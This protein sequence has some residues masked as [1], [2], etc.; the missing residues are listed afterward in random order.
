VGTKAVVRALVLGALACVCVSCGPRM[1]TQVSEKPY[2]SRMPDMPTGTVPTTG[3]LATLTQTQSTLKT[4]PLPQT[5]ETID[6]GRIY[7][8]YYCLMC[9]GGKG[10]GNGPVGQSYVPKPTD[11][12]SSEVARLTDGQLY[13]RM[14]HGPG[15]DPVMAQTVLPEHRWPLVHYIRTLRKH[16]AR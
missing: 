3:R 12:T 11:L 2:K 1:I 7:Y 5:R 8:G 16:P 6:D 13:G 10:D 14:L 4:N 9:H 15:H